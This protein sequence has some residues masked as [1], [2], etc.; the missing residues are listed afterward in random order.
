MFIYCV[1]NRCAYGLSRVP[2]PFLASLTD[3][4]RLVLVWGRRPELKHIRLHNEYGQ[5][6]RIGPKTVLVSQAAAVPKIYAINSS[7][8]KS[9]F[10]NV[11]QTLAK[12][13]PLHTLFNTTD[14]KFHAKL[15]RAVSNAYSMSTLVHFQPY[16]DSTTK[17]FLH[18]IK[19]RYA[20]R[21]GCSCNFGAWLQYY[22]FDVI[23][24]LTFSQRL[25]FL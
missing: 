8:I 7:F 6:I 15:R 10:Y 14:E 18:Q 5:V 2:G 19:T 16:V 23:G 13:R 3:W 24:E 4:W 12:G 22:A 9:D 21:P 17:E 25:G 11:Q 1:Y 20:D